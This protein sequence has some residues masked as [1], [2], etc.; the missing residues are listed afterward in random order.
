VPI[1]SDLGRFRPRVRDLL[2]RSGASF[3]NEIVF[4]LNNV[5]GRDAIVDPVLNVSA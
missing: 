4:N 3:R 2:W 5:A 1:T